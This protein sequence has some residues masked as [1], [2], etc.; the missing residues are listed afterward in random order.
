MVDRRE[1]T[2][3]VS[4]TSSSDPGIVLLVVSSENL[5]TDKEIEILR[6]GS[7][8]QNIILLN[9]VSASRGLQPDL[10]NSKLY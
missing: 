4:A 3:S 1:F 7:R 6:D 2:R 8:G 10:Q 5:L 9:L